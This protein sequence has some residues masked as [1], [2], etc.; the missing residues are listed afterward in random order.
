MNKFKWPMRTVFW[1]LVALFT[2]SIVITSYGA[3]A[4]PNERLS[5]SASPYLRLHADDLVQW[6]TWGDEAFDKARTLSKPL[7][8]SFGYTACHWCHVMQETHFRQP[9]ISNFIN[10]NFIPVLVDR[11]RRTALDETYM[12]VTEVLTQSGGWP[13]TVFLTPELKPFYGTGYIPPEPFLQLI[14]AIT[15][16]WSDNRPDLLAE[17][18][19]LAGLL[20]NYQNRSEEAK[21]ITPE[22]LSKL[23]QELVASFDPVYGGLGQAPKFFQPTVLMFLL[24]RYE[25]D[26][27]LAA[28]EAVEKTLVSVQSGG[29]HDQ[30]EGGFHRYAVDP[31]WRIPHFEKMLYDQAQMTEVYLEAYRLTGNRKYAGT[32]R[33]TLDY[34]LADLTAPDGG[35]YST[36]DA[37][38][39]GEEGTY[40]VWTPEEL[41]E[42]LGTDKAIEA[43]NLF[44]LISDGEFAG[45]I[46]LNLDNVADIQLQDV[47]AIFEKL[48]PARNQRQKPRRDEKILTS[49]NGMM[50]ASFATGAA[51]LGE[52]KYQNAAIK[53]G[54][55]LWQ[56]M[57]TANRG[58]FKSFF[59]SEADVEAELEDYGQ[60]AR[61]YIYLFDL[62]R[63][64]I[65]LE[66]ANALKE[67]ML[68]NFS[69][70]KA[71]DFYA[72]SGS[73]GF[74]RTK[75]RSDIDQPSGNGAAL[76]VL[77]RLAKRTSDAQATLV[78][79]KA[80]A[81]LSGIAMKGKSSGA[82]IL[83]AADRHLRSE[84][85]PVQYAGNGNVRV[86]G[87]Y[88]GKSR[89]IRLK[90]TVAE[91]WHVN[92][93][94]PLEDHLIATEFK[95][96]AGNNPV[97]AET[98]YPKPLV[99][100]LSFNANPVAV[101]EHEFEITASAEA[102]DVQVVEATLDVQT[103]SDEICLLPET[104]K[105]RI[106]VSQ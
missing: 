19:R 22:A 62:T 4:A 42:V 71:G 33:K 38:S 79:E 57:R 6:Y 67:E 64:N 68:E 30:L 5:K 35:F 100:T 1:L 23:S 83:S 52:E 3:L 97:K 96:N 25:R 80:L 55:F 105:F 84:N 92:A 94:K 37:D 11:E 98:A 47:L 99:K 7:L 54:E 95:L 74:A 18:D 73:A 46:I 44:D 17:G 101:L 56:N 104:L 8:V 78:T 41:E 88:Q 82:S 103:C 24:Q 106:P 59:E 70:P 28:L 93:N 13:N 39:E 21:A 20:A 69:D 14:E 49:W 77:A 60:L 102:L 87:E 66:R 50:I 85:G 81:S 36:R 43:V 86:S 61:A 31:A 53:A 89:Q 29:I 26:D 72:T 65:W 40:Y 51:I 48:K 32:A 9:E 27:D 10:E 58:L 12:L 75:L 2:M 15:Q 91:G 63:E 45:K 16:G 34:V 76:D 90:V